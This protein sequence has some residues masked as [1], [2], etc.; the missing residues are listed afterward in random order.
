MQT[1]AGEPR[2]G[3]RFGGKVRAGWRVCVCAL[4]A[5]NRQPPVLDWPLKSVRPSLRNSLEI[6][7]RQSYQNS[8]SLLNR[9]IGILSSARDAMR[10][11]FQ[12]Y[13]AGTLGARRKIGYTRSSLPPFLV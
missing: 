8:E 2:L 11:S 9:K 7:G 12:S 5:I 10:V 1:G 4:D 3:L 13:L 6:A